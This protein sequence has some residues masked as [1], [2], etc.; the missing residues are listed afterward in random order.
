M[1]YFSIW[2]S[3]I[4]AFF[5]FLSEYSRL[6]FSRGVSFLSETSNIFIIIGCSHKKF[7]KIETKAL[8]Q[9]SSSINF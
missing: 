9:K 8:Y 2:T 1:I 4:I 5:I 3:N 6:H 7:F